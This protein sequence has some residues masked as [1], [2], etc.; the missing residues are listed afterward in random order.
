VIAQAIN[1]INFLKKPKQFII[2]IYHNIHPP[3]R[4]WPGAFLT[5]E[6]FG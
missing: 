6:A 3:H 2:S 4:L 5:S 1:L